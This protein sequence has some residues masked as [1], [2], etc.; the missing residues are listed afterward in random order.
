MAS[1]RVSDVKVEDVLE[2]VEAGHD[3][4]PRLTHGMLI[5]VGVVKAR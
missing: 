4:R 5:T 1:L 3:D 2:L